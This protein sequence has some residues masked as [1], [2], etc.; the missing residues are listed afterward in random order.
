MNQY[1]VEQFLIKSVEAKNYFNLIGHYEVLISVKL[2]CG[3]Y[4]VVLSNT[5]LTPT[6]LCISFRSQRIPDLFK[7]NLRTFLT[8]W[9]NHLE[10]VTKYSMLPNLLCNRMPWT[11]VTKTVLSWLEKNLNNKNN[12]FVSIGNFPLLPTHSRIL[13]RFIQ[14]QTDSCSD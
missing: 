7:F 12:F 11:D 5:I 4:K 2:F 1:H 6:L 13:I 10:R 3:S 8:S 14:L 9:I